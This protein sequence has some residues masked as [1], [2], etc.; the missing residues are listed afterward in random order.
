L[1]VLST[2][3]RAPLVLWKCEFTILESYRGATFFQRK[4]M[5]YL[6]IFL[7]PINFLSSV[8]VA[9]FECYIYVFLLTFLYILTEVDR[10]LANG[11]NIKE[12][13]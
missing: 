4:K 7:R 12:E 8:V 1:F 13:K 5:V 10:S 3:A 6:G 9:K 2:Q 11:N